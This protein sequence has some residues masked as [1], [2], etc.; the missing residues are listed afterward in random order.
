MVAL[1]SPTLRSLLVTSRLPGAE[2]RQALRPRVFLPLS[3]NHISEATS[4]RPKLSDGQIRAY[5]K[6]RGPFGSLGGLRRRRTARA[7]AAARRLQ[8]MVPPSALSLCSLLPRFLPHTQPQCAPG[9][10][11]LLFL[12]IFQ[13]AVSTQREEDTGRRGRVL[14]HWLEMEIKEAPWGVPCTRPSWVPCPPQLRRPGL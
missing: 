6:G 5:P 9:G 12:P 8:R 14:G 10:Q 11:R 13:R 7:G 4:S 3:F 2:A 1:A